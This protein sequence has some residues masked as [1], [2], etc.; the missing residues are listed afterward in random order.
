MTLFWIFRSILFLLGFLLLIWGGNVLVNGAVGLAKKLKVS[1]LLIGLV[2]VG[3]GT[4]T[5]ELIT[6]LLAVFGHSDGLAIG[7]IVGSNIINILLV[8][9]AAACIFP[10]A[11][12]RLSLRRDGKFLLLSSAVLVAALFVGK[13]TFLWGLVMCAIL[14]YYVYYAYQTDRRNQQLIAELHESEK[15]KTTKDPLWP[16]LLR[17]ATGIFLTFF[18][19]TILVENAKMLATTLGVSSALIGLTVIAFGTSL[20]EL[21]TSI[22]ASLKKQSDVAFGN[23]IGS[24]IYNA[25]FILG[26]T[27]LFTP[28]IVQPDYDPIP[29]VAWMSAITVILLAIAYFY[30]KLPRWVGVLFLILY[31]VYFVSLVP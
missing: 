11:V 22:V 9:G 14:A 24:N 26:F 17:V 10:I 7:N 31:C 5:P 6:S 16:H 28:V 20:P 4:S 30:R 13:I 1:P 3:F 2:V 21:V 18:G 27:A 23:I 19:A 25:L 12:P 15:Q 29:D 8:L